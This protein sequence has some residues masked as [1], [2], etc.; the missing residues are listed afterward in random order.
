MLI[1]G[2]KFLTMPVQEADWLYIIGLA[3]DG[4]VDVNQVAVTGY[5]FFSPLS[6][7]L[8]LLTRDICSF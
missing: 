5:A 1:S 6:Y 3:S 2:V 8:H 7:L 4:F